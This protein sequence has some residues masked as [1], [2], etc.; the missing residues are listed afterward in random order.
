MIS[1]A[2]L[3]ALSF[4]E[5]ETVLPQSSG[6]EHK[7]TDKEFLLGYLERS[8]DNLREQTQDLDK[9]QLQY[10]ISGESWSISQCLEH[11]IETEKAIFQMTRELLGQPAN[12]ER[13]PEI[14][15]TDQQLVEAME[16]RSVKAKA[17]ADLRPSGIYTDP[18][19]A[20]KDLLEHRSK[21]M[22]LIRDI[23][24]EELRD[25]VTDSPMGPID[26]YQSL[27]FIA[28][29]TARHTAQIAEVKSDPDFPVAD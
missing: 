9:D 19:D 22:A 14:K 10:R 8:L 20:L 11:I 28:G 2:I 7:V 17:P 5:R 3:V 24:E 21:V 29:H 6:S 15:N 27:L 16:D 25:R 13:R 26:G 4:Q 23:S 1:I 12:P 18:Q